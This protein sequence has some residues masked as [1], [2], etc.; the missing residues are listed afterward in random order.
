MSKEARFQRLD[1][2]VRKAR[3][4]EATLVC[5]QRHGFQGTSIRRI[6]AEAGVSIGLLNHHYSGKDELVADAYREVTQR[7]GALMR[8]AVAGADP[9][10][11]HRLGAYFRASFSP[12]VLNPRLLDAYLAFWGAVK[13]AEVINRAHEES[14]AGYYATLSEMLGELAREQRWEGFDTR[15]AAISLS[16]MLDGLWLEYGLDPRTFKPEQ[17]VQMCEAWIDGLV[18]GAWRRFTPGT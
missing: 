8:A 17:G 10:P 14:Y 7:M 3:F 16:A 5:L 1:P 18:G 12:E 2:A 6:C 11:R 9:T 13:S 15:L 4:V